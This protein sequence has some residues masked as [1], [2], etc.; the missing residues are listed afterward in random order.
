MGLRS[1]TAP[2]FHVA[3]LAWPIPDPAAFDA[4]LLTSANAPRHAGRGLLKLA[5]LPCLCVGDATAA[6]ARRAGLSDV[7]SGSGD[8]KAAVELLADQGL[9]RV[10]HLCGRDHLGLEQPGIEIARIAVYAAEA[11]GSLPATALDTLRSGAVAL[12]HSP[13]AGRLLGRLADEAGL[14]RS[15]VRVAAISKA[16]AEAAG[17]GWAAVAVAPVPRDQPLLEVAAKL[18]NSEADSGTGKRE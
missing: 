9:R 18:C 13:R 8:G 6:E 16:A 3:P 1:V 12:I 17:Q 11:A 15:G 5:R 14:E 7:R 4:L 10:L 2:L